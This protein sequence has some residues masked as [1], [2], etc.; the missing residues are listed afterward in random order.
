MNPY[1]LSPE[2]TALLNQIEDA[3]ENRWPLVQLDVPVCRRVLRALEEHFIAQNS[4]GEGEPPKEN[5]TPARREALLQNLGA[6]IAF[7]QDAA[8]KA[9]TLLEGNDGPQLATALRSI[10]QASRKT[11]RYCGELI[12]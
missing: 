4:A 8:G 9:Q 5:M 10:Q 12:G 6:E 3:F 11:A 2:Q 1:V 7:I